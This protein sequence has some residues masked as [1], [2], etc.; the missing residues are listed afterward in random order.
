MLRNA[1][2]IAAVA[3]LASASAHAYDKGQLTCDNIGKLAAYTLQA[4]QSGVAYEELLTALQQSMPDEAQIERRVATQITTLVYQSDVLDAMKPED[5]YVVF[6][7]NCMAAPKGD[8]Q[9]PH[10][11]EQP[12]NQS[13][14][15]R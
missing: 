3:L 6:A 8:E 5:A 11:D 13:Q 10:G 15:M 14:N 7:Q 4:K 12:E 2:T 9:L 1:Y